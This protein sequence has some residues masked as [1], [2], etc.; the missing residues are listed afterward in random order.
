MVKRHETYAT[1]QIPSQSKSIAYYFPYW[2]GKIFLLEAVYEI[3]Y[4]QTH[5]NCK[6]GWVILEVFFFCNGG[7]LLFT[8]SGWS[9][10]CFSCDEIIWIVMELRFMLLCYK[11][12]P[13]SAAHKLLL[14]YLFLWVYESIWPAN[15]HAVKQITFIHMYTHSR[16]HLQQAIYIQWINTTCTQN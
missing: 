14:D 16:Q 12:L 5:S 8:S 15:M 6:V 2:E 7:E 11:I 1:C 4:D 3:M 13:P 9:P 10:I